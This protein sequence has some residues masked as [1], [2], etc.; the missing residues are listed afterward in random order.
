MTDRLDYLQMA[1]DLTGSSDI[2]V[3]IQAARE[4][5]NFNA[6]TPKDKPTGVPCLFFE[7]CAYVKT[8]HPVSG[9]VPWPLLYDFQRDFA[10]TLCWRARH[11]ETTPLIHLTSRQ[12]GA[13][14]MLSAFALWFGL[15][16]RRQK[17]AML[18]PK[19][20]Q[21]QE[22]RDRIHLM[23]THL[24]NQFAPGGSE[25][26]RLYTGSGSEIT[27]GSFGHEASQ[28]MARESDLLILCDLAF[29][30]YSQDDTYADIINSVSE[31]NGMVVAS[32]CA[33]QPAGLFYKLFSQS[34]NRDKV[35]HRWDAHPNRNASWEAHFKKSLGGDNFAREMGCEFRA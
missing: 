10:N 1:K 22:S 8:Q 25:E 19:M 4:L 5:E 15:T 18:F 30:S 29:L 17:I 32:S 3:L 27:F 6:E 16:A 11:P 31:R 7:F 13:T 12:M 20:A 9:M 2:H 23:Q 34:E 21:A 28:K 35:V 24:P 26:S 14:T 33:N